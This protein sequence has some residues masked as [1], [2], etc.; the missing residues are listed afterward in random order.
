MFLIIAGLIIWTLAHL[1]R[2][3]APQIR[4]SLQDRFG[5]GA[6]GIMAV[7]I[8][9]SVILMITGY[10]SADQLLLWSP[11]LWLWSINNLLMLL[12]LYMYFTTATKPGTAFIFG[13]L[14][15]PQLTGFKV[16]AAAHL[17]VNGDLASVVLFGG[18]LAWA[19]IQV[20]AAKRTVSLVDR[21]TAPISSPWVH[22]A[23][24]VAA[25]FAIAFI[26]YWLG[27]YPFAV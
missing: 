20:I 9:I 10:R 25:F 15:N 23:L 11:P 3:L 13:S 14:K 19:V 24:S 2:S 4:Q 5:N 21:N 6:K 27:A 18:L 22:A 16:W 12:A 17:L 7:V 8:V 26:H 1:L